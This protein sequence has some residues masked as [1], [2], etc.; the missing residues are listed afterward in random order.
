MTM[1]SWLC[2]L[3]AITGGTLLLCGV[4]L[5]FGLVSVLMV[6]GLLLIS[7]A[8]RLAWVLKHRVPHANQ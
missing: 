7:Y 5:A 1:I 2:D 6:A 3:V 4:Y 8:T